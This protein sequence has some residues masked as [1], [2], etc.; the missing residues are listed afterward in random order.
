MSRVWPA[1]V[2]QARSVDDPSDAPER[3]S[4][5]LDDHA[6]RAIEDLAEQPLP[7]G[8]VW[9]PTC[10]PPPEGPPGPV[11]WRVFFGDDR[12]RDEAARAIRQAMPAL[13]VTAEDVPDDDWAARSQATLTAV[14]AGAFIIAPPWDIPAPVRDATLIVIEPSMGFGTGHHATTRLCLRLLSAVD[15]S[16]RRTLDLGTGS[17]VLAIGAA[18]K[19][20]REVEGVD[21]DP[22]AIAS[23]RRSAR[24]NALPIAVQWRVADF[25]TKPL[26]PADVVLANLTG[27][28]LTSA[29]PAIV[30]LVR[31][32]GALV[33]G[34]LDI[35]EADLVRRAFGELAEEARLDEECWV[36]L[37]LRR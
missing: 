7:P 4:A 18:L 35:S 32:G 33:V 1:L 5:I 16:G 36:A 24:L 20:A 28:M 37:L 31:S 23:A 9:D 14:R 17:G 10:P 15:V 25:R 29:A 21:V 30:R 34:G 8:G 27:G 22:D 12:A 3:L 13:Q 2:I 6:L 26:E 11:R 19:G